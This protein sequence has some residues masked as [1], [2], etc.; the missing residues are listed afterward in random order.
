MHVPLDKQGPKLNYFRRSKGSS[1][2]PVA[3]FYF[4]ADTQPHRIPG[5]PWTCGIS[6]SKS[7]I[8]AQVNN[9]SG[10]KI[11]NAAANAYCQR[12]VWARVTPD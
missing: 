1:A 8:A 9:L 11:V 2:P 7:L 10:V 12:Q 6:R 4:G 3:Q 5:E